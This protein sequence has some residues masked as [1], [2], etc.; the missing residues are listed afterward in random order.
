MKTLVKELQEI[1]DDCEYPF[2]DLKLVRFCF[3][4]FIVMKV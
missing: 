2:V 3:Y 1:L 4:W